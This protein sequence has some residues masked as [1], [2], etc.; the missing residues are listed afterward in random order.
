M[1][2]WQA[3]R[4]RAILSE[5]L[6]DTL[7]RQWLTHVIRLGRHNTP[8]DGIAKSVIDRNGHDYVGKQAGSGYTMRSAIFHLYSSAQNITVRLK[9]PGNKDTMTVQTDHCMPSAVDDHPI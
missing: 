8:D 4:L 9:L 6:R 7:N 2:V 3:D 1:I 5:S